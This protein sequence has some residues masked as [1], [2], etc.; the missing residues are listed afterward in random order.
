MPPKIA[1]GLRNHKIIKDEH[2]PE[3]VP[4]KGELHEKIKRLCSVLF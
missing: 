3:K 4:Q 1:P 2:S